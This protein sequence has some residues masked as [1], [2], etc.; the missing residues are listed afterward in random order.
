MAMTDPPDPTGAPPHEYIDAF[1]RLSYVAQRYYGALDG[2]RG[3]CDFAF[4]FES[5]VALWGRA[6]L[7]AIDAIKSI[8]GRSPG[9]LVPTRIQRLL[10]GFAATVRDQFHRWNYDC[11]LGPDG[12]D[13]VGAKLEAHDRERRIPKLRMARAWRSMPGVDQCDYADADKDTAEDL[14]LKPFELPRG[15]TPE[16]AQVRYVEL[17]NA[18]L[19]S[20]ALG[21]SDPSATR[22]ELMNLAKSCDAFRAYITWNLPDPEPGSDGS[23]HSG[24]GTQSGAD[25]MN[26]AGTLPP[27]ETL[28]SSWKQSPEPLL[29]EGDPAPS[30][31]QPAPIAPKRLPDPVPQPDADLLIIDPKRLAI[32]SLTR[33][34]VL[35]GREYLIKHAA[36][37]LVYRTVAEARGKPVDTKDLQKLPTCRGRIDKMLSKH[38]PAEVR[39]TIKGNRGGGGYSLL[40][41]PE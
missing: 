8:A 20:P 27:V 2:G 19:I 38:L 33:M 17:Q 31:D 23:Q 36:S 13:L 25:V 37:F 6:C 3:F 7:E 22:D 14:G 30:E 21:E 12:P 18:W 24:S 34:V 28:A 4:Q 35:N 5:F 1:R 10:D 16:E 9:R 32:R 41:G 11:F 40:L 29:P 39:R 26:G 15:T